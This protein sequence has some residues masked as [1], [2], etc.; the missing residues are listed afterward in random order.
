M[1]SK[2]LDHKL[3]C[4]ACGTILLDI[5]NNAEEHTAIHCSQCGAYLGEW[6]ELQDDFHKQ[7]GDTQAFDLN[8][9]N[10]VKK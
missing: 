5:P 1:D 4:K 2:R 10:I 9:G 8:H 7:A 3:D 6:G